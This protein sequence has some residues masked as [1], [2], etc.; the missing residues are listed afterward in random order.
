MALSRLETEHYIAI[1]YLA[2]PKRGGLTMQEIA[3]KSSVTRSTIYNW[4]DDPVF[5]AELKRRIIR[6][7]RDRL[8]EMVN[9][10]ADAVVDDHNAAMFKLVLQ[11]ND[12]LTDVVNVNDKLDQAGDIDAMQKRIEEYRQKTNKE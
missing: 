9:A 7:S 2:L 10:A 12:M 3:E 11:M 4:L 8:P 1:N 5:S 6:N